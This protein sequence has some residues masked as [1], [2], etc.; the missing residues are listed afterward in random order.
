MIWLGDFIQ[1][2]YQLEFPLLQKHQN[3]I[4]CHPKEITLVKTD[5]EADEKRRPR[6]YTGKGEEE[7]G[8]KNT[9]I[10]LLEFL[11]C[12]YSLLDKSI[13][14]QSYIY[15]VTSKPKKSFIMKL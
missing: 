1:G 10:G 4:Y 3:Q 9:I 6:L 15:F 7:D 11:D 12:R 2:G 14:L 8:Y 13:Y 5:I